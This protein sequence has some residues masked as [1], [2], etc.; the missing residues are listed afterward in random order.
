MKLRDKF[1]MQDRERWMREAELNLDAGVPQWTRVS[2]RFYNEMLE[3]LPPA[4][5]NRNGFV[6]PE[7]LRHND[8]GKAIV[9][10]FRHMHRGMP[11]GRHEMRYG[12]LAE[13]REI[14]GTDGFGSL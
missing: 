12:T 10:I 11:M 2:S 14:L 6:M 5:H 3:V 4:I 1:Y 7:P 8:E 9:M 13:A